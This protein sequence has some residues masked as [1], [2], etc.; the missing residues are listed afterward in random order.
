MPTLRYGGFHVLSVRQWNT[1]SISV[2]MTLKPKPYLQQVS[3]RDDLEFDFED[4]PLSIP[5]IRKMG[6]LDFHPDVTFFVGENGSG[7][8]TILEAIAL[9]L[10]FGPEG[11]VQKTSNFVLLIRFPLFTRCLK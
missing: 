3:L 1:P 5:A 10:G 11:G 7:K 9:G 6:T 4:F 2:A 8:S